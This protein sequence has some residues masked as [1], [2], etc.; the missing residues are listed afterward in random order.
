M[1]TK[2]SSEI[3]K[4]E[5]IE[6]RESQRK[7]L[8]SGTIQN[9]LDKLIYPD[10]SYEGL[11]I[12][13]SE[14]MSKDRSFLSRNK[15]R[16]SISS[17]SGEI[18]ENS[19][20]KIPT[21]F[22]WREGGNTVYVTGNFANWKQWFLMNKSFNNPN[23]FTLTLDL[24][25]GIYQFKFIVDK[26]WKYSNHLPQFKDEHGNINN[27][28]DNQNIYPISRDVLKAKVNYK[29]ISFYK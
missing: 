21:R 27:M 19:N 28:I 23:E 9:G 16:L 24:P 7:L 4:E 12:D 2:I 13:E 3:S 17:V 29:M 10:S 15:S 14:S 18:Q 1:G 22:V 20:I 8:M 11:K 26:V 5:E 25:R 6:D